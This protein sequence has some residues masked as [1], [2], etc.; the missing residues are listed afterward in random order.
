M[1]IYKEVEE[2]KIKPFIQ[3]TELFENADE[4]NFAFAEVRKKFPMV[5][6]ESSL[7]VLFSSI[8]PSKSCPILWYRNSQF[9]PV[10]L[11]EF[12]KLD[13]L[14]QV[15]NEEEKRRTRIYHAN[16][17]LSQ[18]I[19]KY[20]KAHLEKKAA[21]LEIEKWFHVKFIP[22]S[23]M[24]SVNEKM[25]ADNQ[26]FTEEAYFEFLDYK[27]IIDTNSELKTIFSHPGVGFAWLDKL[28]ELRR[29]PAH[30]DKPAPKEDE[31]Q[32]FEKIKE[33]ILPKL[34]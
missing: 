19:N 16:V 6:R 30:T 18:A 5:N 11:N 21:E 15:D 32:Y 3:G 28:N 17:K 12:G 8:C 23:V 7:L 22:K 31:A 14:K 10:F 24:L 2:T 20:I 29:Y 13:E 1:I 27:K 4:S 33:Y 26:K 25:I 34:I 9:S